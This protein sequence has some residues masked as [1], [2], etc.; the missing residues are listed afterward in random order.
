MNR[1]I[2]YLASILKKELGRHIML[3]EVCSKSTFEI[4]ENTLAKVAEYE[5]ADD[6]EGRIQCEICEGRFAKDDM[7]GEL[8]KNTCKL[9]FIQGLRERVEEAKPE[10]KKK[11]IFEQIFDR[12]LHKATMDV[13][14]R[15]D[16]KTRYNHL[17]KA[18]GLACEQAWGRY[19]S[20]AKE[21]EKE[22]P[23]M[24]AVGKDMLSQCEPSPVSLSDDEL[25]QLI[26]DYSAA[27]EIAKQIL[28]KQ[29]VRVAG[30]LSQLMKQHK[31]KYHSEAQRIYN[32]VKKS[33]IQ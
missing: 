29:I 8:G 4:F 23:N 22:P 32:E 12:L 21:D 30:T 20:T 10:Q 2:R 5:F 26:K 9:C 11:E 19:P 31:D 27:D 28:E 6:P 17:C 33:I 24:P 3:K 25:R 18:L 15:I 7:C 16:E 13:R 14:K 1:D